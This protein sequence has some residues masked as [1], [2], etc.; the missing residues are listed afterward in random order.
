MP[1]KVRPKCRHCKTRWANRPRHLCWRCYYT[2]GVLGR[3]PS[4]S[5]FAN[6]G[7]GNGMAGPVKDAAPTGVR[8]G[9]E[10]VAVLARRAAAGEKLWH[11]LDAV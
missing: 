3:Y 8:P 5:K 2:P 7:Y 4:T 6:R 1:W 10:K 9:P 11:P